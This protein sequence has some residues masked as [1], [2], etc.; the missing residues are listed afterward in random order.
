MKDTERVISETLERVKVIDPHCH[1]SMENPAAKDLADILQYHHLWT[2]LV[3]SGMDQLEVTESG[4]PQE[5]QDPVIEARER[6]RRCLKYLPNLKNTTV[7]LFLKWILHDLYEEDELTEDNFTEVFDKVEKKGK[8][9]GWLEEV[10]RERCHIEYNISVEHSGTPVNNRLL[11]G[12]EIYATN[13]VSGK[14]NAFEMLQDWEAFL[15]RDITDAQSYSDFIEKTVQSLPIKEYRFVGLWI[16]PCVCFEYEKHN[17]LARIFEKVKKG[18][19]LT[20]TDAGGLCYFGV[21]TLLE[22]LRQTPLRLIQLIVGAEVLPPHRSITHWHSSF[23][24][25]IAR[26]ANAFED[27]HFNLSSA[28]D[29]YTQDLGILSKHLPNISVAG[30]WWHTLYPFYI[31]K[32]LE[33][34]LDMVPLNKIIAF[35][36]DAYHAEWCYPKLK[37]VKQILQ[38]ILLERI[39]KAWYSLDVAIDIINKIFYENPS[40]IY[41]TADSDRQ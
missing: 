19:I 40:R 17:Q 10:L 32:N 1:L 28:S 26:I 5:L 41:K 27:F 11:K 20:Q 29:L 22:L 25:S 6:V 4:L 38:Q 16:L 35:F 34:R 2:E 37:M 7:G 9:A 8:D 13:I 33:T 18:E 21:Q 3:S 24:G 14:T 31:K 23:S 30:Y 12:R 36:S 39:D 15:G